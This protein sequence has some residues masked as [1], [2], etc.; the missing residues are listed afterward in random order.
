MGVGRVGCIALVAVSLAGCGPRGP[1]YPATRLEGAVTV[2]GQPLASG[3][4]QFLPEHAGQ[5]PAVGTT[6]E[7][8]RYEVENVPL[9][10]VRAIVTSVR[11]GKRLPDVGD[12]PVWEAENLVP[13]NRRG[14][15]LIQVTA[16][17]P[18]QDLRL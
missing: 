9:G 16:D 4:I 6:I 13:E 7:D 11:R 1:G 17:Q 8:G 3:S 15:I 12:M 14:G 2:D 18:I 10:E 5:G